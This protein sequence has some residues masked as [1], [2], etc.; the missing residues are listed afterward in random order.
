MIETVRQVKLHNVE[1]SSIQEPPAASLTC[2]SQPGEVILI[3][4]QHGQNIRNT[5]EYKAAQNNTTIQNKTQ[6]LAQS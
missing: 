1:M 6:K 5:F 4:C 2:Q 3:V